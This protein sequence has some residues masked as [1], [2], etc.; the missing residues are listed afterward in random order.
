MEEPCLRQIIK[1]QDQEIMSPTAR[2]IWSPWNCQ[3]HEHKYVLWN[4]KEPSINDITHLGGEG[5]CQKVMLLPK[6]I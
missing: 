5:I 1:I 3:K 6:P 4:D 2:P